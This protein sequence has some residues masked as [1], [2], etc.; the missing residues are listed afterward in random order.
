MQNFFKPMTAEGAALSNLVSSLY[1][2]DAAGK[3]AERDA[4]IAQRQQDAELKKA[5]IDKYRAE[6]E[7]KNAARKSEATAMVDALAGLFGGAPQG[8]AVM[9]FRNAGGVQSPAVAGRP[10]NDDEGFAMPPEPMARPAG[11][12]PQM[13]DLTNRLFAGTALSR[14]LPGK[15]NF[16]QLV[17]GGA[18]MQNQNIVADVLAGLQTPQAASSAVAAGKGLPF[19][20]ESQGRVLDKYGG[21]LNESG[22]QA[23]ANVGATGAKTVADQALGE[24]RRKQAGVI[25]PNQ[26]IEG[27]GGATFPVAG[28]DLSRA[29]TAAMFPKAGAGG[30]QK[31]PKDFKWSA[32]GAQLEL[33][34]GSATDLKR[35]DAVTKEVGKK[36]V[37]DATLDAEIAN[38][39]KL[40]GR[41]DGSVKE[42]PGLTS[43]VGSVDALIPSIMPDTVDAEALI[44]SLKSKASISA[45]QTIRSSAGAIGSLTE[46]EW[47]RL[48]SLKATLQTRQSNQQYRQSLKEYRNELLRIK[49]VAAEEIA[50]EAQR[51]AA[52]EMPLAGD[53]PTVTNDAEWAALP[54]GTKFKAPDGSV[55]QK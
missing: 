15:T 50:R 31:A 38:I 6:T 53:M 14:A 40:I 43:A 55:R 11:Y 19:F 2:P 4:L 41:D 9:D 24:L 44:E 20:S 13:E 10:V 47:P 28:G 35:R 5:Q 32:D 3:R 27:P 51:P 22:P 49:R 54:P 16:Q 21:A 33:I 46:K 18:G 8:Q 7:A 12:T 36:K 17:A 30:Q 39:D 23:V 45:L 25:L 37:L 42:H 26:T 34:P 29:V 52:P 1:S 48:E